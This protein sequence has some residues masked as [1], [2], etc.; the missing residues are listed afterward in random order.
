MKNTSEIKYKIN[1]LIKELIQFNNSKKYVC[2]DSP[3]LN[4]TKAVH[5]MDVIID[6]I[7]YDKNFTTQFKKQ[8]FS[9]KVFCFNMPMNK[10]LNLKRKK[11]DLAYL[12]YCGSP[13][14]KKNGSS[15]PVKELIKISDLLS[16]YAIVLITYSFR[17]GKDINHTLCKKKAINNI[18]EAGL[19]ILGVWKYN[20]TSPMM[21]CIACKK[22]L[23]KSKKISI[24]KKINILLNNI[25]SMKEVCQRQCYANSLSDSLIMIK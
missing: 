14:N 5:K 13:F 15:L 21:L 9:N 11:I 20:E 22:R 3:G 1:N 8:N 18:D 10:Y 16:R 17:A 4:S 7:C 6:T 19:Y 2:I 24:L 25:T 12:D 23:S